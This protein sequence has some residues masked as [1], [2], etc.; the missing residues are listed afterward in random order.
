MSLEIVLAPTSIPPTRDHRDTD[1]TRKCAVG[2]IAI[3]RSFRQLVSAGSHWMA[4]TCG[5]ACVV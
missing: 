2:G 4:Y 5:L 1:E 3:G